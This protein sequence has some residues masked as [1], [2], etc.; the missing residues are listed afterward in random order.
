MV[1][2]DSRPQLVP[3]LERARGTAFDRAMSR[4]I[5]VNEI[6][7]FIMDRMDGTVPVSGI[8]AEIAE[9]FGISEKRALADT[10]AFID[11]L[12]SCGVVNIR[13]P[14]GRYVLTL[15]TSVFALG[16]ATLN[17]ART[18]LFARRRAD[19]RGTS[20]FSIFAQIFL[21]LYSRHLWLAA[22]LMLLCGGFTFVLLGE[23]FYALSVPAAVYCATIFGMSLHE[24]AHLY[25]LRRCTGN[26]HLGYLRL[27]PLQISICYPGV[28]PEVNFRVALAGPL[29]PT[30]CGVAIYAVGALYPNPLLAVGAL[31]L[32]AHVLNFLPLFASDGAN[33]LSYGADARAGHRL[34]DENSR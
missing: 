26:G 34:V 18:M 6:G 14:A 31:M 28:G 8:A 12:M 33:L 16:G 29:C 20:F 19:V 22:Y 3:R 23:I 4:R 32:V 5:E 7:E 10:S 24:G 11:S 2:P 25:T 13:Y 17:D 15:L 1:T 21:Q 27:T 9:R 30:V